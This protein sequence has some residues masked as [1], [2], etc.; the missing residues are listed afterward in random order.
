M[1]DAN[2]TLK[3]NNDDNKP[4]KVICLGL[5]ILLDLIVLTGAIACFSTKK[6]LDLIIYAAVFAV[7]LLI[8]IAT[9]FFTF[10]VIISY[11]K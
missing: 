7:A 6:Y 10:E 4:A 11:E 8:R 1:I 2:Y 3:Y 9:L 5:C